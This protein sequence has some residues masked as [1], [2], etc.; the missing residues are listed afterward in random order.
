MAQFNTTAIK[1]DGRLKI[2][3][4]EDI[5][6]LV[7]S[8]APF[9]AI[10][11]R[12]KSGTANSYKVEWLE[13]ETEARADLVNGAK[14]AT[15][16]VITVDNGAYFRP[17]F[18]V[19]IPRTGEVMLV[20]SVSNND[21]T[22]KRA[23]GTTAAAAIDDNDAIIILANA[24]AEGSGAPLDGGSAITQQYNLTQI[25]KTPFSCTNT[26]NAVKI[27]GS[28]KLITQEQKDAGVSHR[29]D[30]ERSFLFGERKEDLTGTN[31]LRTAGGVLSFLKDNIYNVA[32]GSLSEIEFN[33]WLEG[34]FVYGSQK[35]TL[36]ASPRLVSVIS[37]W[38]GAKLQTVSNASAKYGINVVEYIS[39]HGTLNIVKHP[40]LVGN[41]SG[42]GICLDMADVEYKSLEGRD[43]NL[44]TNI[45]SNDSDIRRDMYLTEATIVVKMSKH[46][47]VI[48]GVVN[49]A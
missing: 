26:A 15:D 6:L 35:K 31:P 18:L 8:A 34:V 7:P 44:Q 21:I 28:N 25:V 47:G 2:D 4:S 9:T 27:Y 17:G 19:K 12:I 38:A 36:F 22:V 30:L 1:S 42:M 14:L 45:Q 13:R 46:H 39:P 23:F 41:Y 20:S 3:M 5:A 32:D 10:T 24:S 16:T 33:N 29:L 11:K 43:T 40:L 37:S 48:T 49:P